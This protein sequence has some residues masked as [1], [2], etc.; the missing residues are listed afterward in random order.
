MY[1][2]STML[3]FIRCCLTELIDL[4]DVVPLIY[5]L[6]D[7]NPICH[8]PYVEKPISFQVESPLQF[9]PFHILAQAKKFF[10]SIEQTHHNHPHQL[11]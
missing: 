4:K 6:I 8:L 7:Y 3:R 1:V 9:S 11:Q 5:N 2:S 10:K